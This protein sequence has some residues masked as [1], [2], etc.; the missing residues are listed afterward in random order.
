LAEAAVGII[1]SEEAASAS[2]IFWII[3]ILLDSGAGRPGRYGR[4]KGA[5]APRFL[6]RT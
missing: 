3:E 4:L 5:A 1:A 2:A 6:S